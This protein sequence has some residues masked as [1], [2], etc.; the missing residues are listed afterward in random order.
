[1][2]ILKKNNF[3]YLFIFYKTRN[4]KLIF[5]NCFKQALNIFHNFLILVPSITVTSLIQILAIIGQT[6]IKINYSNLVLNHP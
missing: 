4:R 6:K 1:M 5:E 3:I 2:K